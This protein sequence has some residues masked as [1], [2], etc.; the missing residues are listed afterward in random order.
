MNAL[1]AWWLARSH[2]E[3]S[4]ASHRWG[5]AGD[6]S[7]VGPRGESSTG[8]RHGP[9]AAATCSPTLTYPKLSTKD[10]DFPLGLLFSESPFHQIL[11]VFA[12]KRHVPFGDGWI[13]CARQHVRLRLVVRVE[14]AGVDHP[15][16]AVVADLEAAPQL[17]YR[18]RSRGHELPTWIKHSVGYAVRSDINV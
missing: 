10:V 6:E 9:L 1:V 8:H 15:Q 14:A 16:G 3:L 7:Q 13:G 4:M 18:R 17:V 5:W 2:R 12:G 11:T